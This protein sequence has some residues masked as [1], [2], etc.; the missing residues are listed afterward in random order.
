MSFKFV[1]GSELIHWLKQNFNKMNMVI[2]LS[3]SILC[4]YNVISGQIYE[5]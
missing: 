5:K 4:V 3:D 1:F 2:K